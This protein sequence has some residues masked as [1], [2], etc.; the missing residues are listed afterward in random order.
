MA[1]TKAHNRMIAGSGVNVLDYG[2]VPDDATDSASAIQAAINAAASAGLP[3]IIDEQYAVASAIT[4][5]SN[6]TII[7]SGRLRQTSA[8]TNLLIAGNVENITIRNV[9]LR[10]LGT[11][12]DGESFGNFTGRNG[13][14]LT[15]TVAV[16]NFVFDGVTFENF[17]GNYIRF[18]GSVSAN[19]ILVTNCRF[20][21][22]NLY[23]TS[24][25]VVPSGEVAG[26]SQFAITL[27]R[28]DDAVI[29][30]NLF[31][32]VGSGVQT[33]S[34][35]NNVAITNNHMKNMLEQHG[36]YLQ[37]P[38]GVVVSGNIIDGA[39][40]TG[41][42]C[43]FSATT[44]VNTDSSMSITGNVVMNAKGNGINVVNTGAD[45]TVLAKNLT[46]TGNAVYDA[47]SDAIDVNHVE[48]AVIAGNTIRAGRS[49]I[50]F[51][52]GVNVNIADNV[53]SNVDA[54]GIWIDQI[55]NG[56]CKRVKITSNTIV[57]P[58]QDALTA[59]EHGIRFGS[60]AVVTET[61]EEILL[62]GNY[63]EDTAS[64]S[65]PMRY[66]VF[67]SRAD[68]QGALRIKNNIGR[69]ARDYGIR[70]QATTPALLEND[71]NVWEG[72]IGPTTS[73]PVTPV[74]QGRVRGVYSGDAAPTTGTYV[75][76]D[77]VYDESPAAGGTLGWVCTAGGTPGTWKTFGAISA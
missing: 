37:S 72:G 29:S 48:N 43:Q 60:T 58:C 38:I 50:V 8:D 55:N 52:N 75:I 34:P 69:N 5:P 40:F 36:T 68:P 33:G 66:A 65:P 21:G 46:I 44:V 11:D 47:A 18:N 4:L 27:A 1:L 22:T 31:V 56:V 19:Q 54:V 24:M 13:F 26:A 17:G 62:D 70:F 2:A 10:G 73:M 25:P 76:G 49:G 28:A 30:N 57:D 39:E 41:I 7:G 42:K 64:S 20:F 61:C 63:I 59:T 45:P 67:V 51:A 9:T 14:L 35:C 53:I 77:I 71:N 15:N 32:E 16:S 74:T 6:T 23:G 12:Y 3:V